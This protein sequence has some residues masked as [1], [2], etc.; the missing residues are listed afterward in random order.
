MDR[1][2]LLLS[3]KTLTTLPFHSKHKATERDVT[4]AAEKRMEAKLLAFDNSFGKDTEELPLGSSSNTT[5]GTSSGTSSQKGS[6]T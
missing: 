2:T 4:R 5:S 3:D 1:L 6:R